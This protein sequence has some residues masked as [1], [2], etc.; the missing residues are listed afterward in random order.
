M[1]NKIEFIFIKFIFLHSQLVLIVKRNKLMNL[2]YLPEYLQYIVIDFIG[3]Y[4]LRNGKYCR[5]LNTDLDFCKILSNRPMPSSITSSNVFVISNK[6]ISMNY[7]VYFPLCYKVFE[8]NINSELDEEMF[9]CK[10]LILS[11]SENDRNMMIHE[12]KYFNNYNQCIYL[13]E[14][15]WLQ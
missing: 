13:T 12:I 15:V 4:K 3:G 6:F 7:Q 10:Y 8:E 1:V 9:V 5:Q 11:Y 2:K 14:S